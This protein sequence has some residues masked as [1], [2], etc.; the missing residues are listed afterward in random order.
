V[1]AEDMLK[2]F[3]ELDMPVFTTRD[4]AN[5]T[6]KSASYAK[7][8]L[9]LLV[10]KN[11][12]EK[13]ERG[14]YCIIGTSPYVIASR[15]TKR[16]YIALLSAA[17]FH[18]ITT[19]LPNTIQVFSESYHRPITIKDNYKVRFILVNKKILYGFKEYNG[20]Y[21]S[22][23]EK[24]FIDDIY[25]NKV[26]VYSE[27]LETAIKTGILKIERLKEY[28]TVLGNARIAKKLDIALKKF[29]TDA[30]LGPQYER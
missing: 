23:I 29:G 1:K 8:F 15:I 7:V 26:L 9:A 16:S 6:G 30:G 12:I 27:E 21:V 24:I 10:K 28:T 5:L 17:R 13:I 4:V 22:E 18:N 19:Q 3:E 2:R 14:R 25:Y 11:K 20:A